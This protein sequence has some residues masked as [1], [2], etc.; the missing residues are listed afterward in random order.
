MVNYALLEAVLEVL[1]A[2]RKTLG[3]DAEQQLR[4]HGQS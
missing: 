3:L 4:S 2:D 1:E